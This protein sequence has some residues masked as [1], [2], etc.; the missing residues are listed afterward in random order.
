MRIRRRACVAVTVSAVLLA[1]AG[2]GKSSSGVNGGGSGDLWGKTVQ[3]IVGV[4]DD[5]FYITMIC[6]AQEEAKKQGVKF[7]SNGSA[8]WGVSQQRPIIDSGAATK[9]AGLLISP[10]DTD[11]LSPDLKQMQSAGTKGGVVGTTGSAKPIGG[12]R[13]SSGNEAGGKTAAHGPA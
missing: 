11:A 10:G 8:Q 9:P 6:G 3:L 13:V 1:A 12:S 4:K 7:S 5:P 2:C